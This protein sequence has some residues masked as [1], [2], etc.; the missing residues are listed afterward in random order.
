[1]AKNIQ[2]GNIIN[3]LR[4]FVGISISLQTYQNIVYLL[5]MLPLG[6]LYLFII[7]VGFPLAISLLP[8]IIGVPLLFVVMVVTTKL[9][10]FDRRLTKRLLN[11]DIPADDAR[12]EPILPIGVSRFRPGTDARTK[13]RASL[14]DRSTWSDYLVSV[15]ELVYLGSKHVFGVVAW[16][17]LTIGLN[18]GLVFLLSPLHYRYPVIGIHIPRDIQFMPEFVYQYATWQVDFVLPFVVKIAQGEVFSNYIDSTGALL[19]S[20]AIGVLLTLLAL[21]A[22][23]S[24]A[25]LYGRFAELMLRSRDDPPSSD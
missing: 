4:R 14:A 9:V 10:A 24:T 25:Q 20:V 6:I 17:V 18:T 13:P 8:F 16:L 23:N 21:H 1:M 15:R 3:Y 19:L 5:L 22:V 11:V 7:S 2:I 12:R